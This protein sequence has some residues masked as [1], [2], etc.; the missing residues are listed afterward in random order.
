MAERPEK[1][2]FVFNADSGVINALKD[3]VHKIVSPKTYECNL[4]AVTYG[5]VS[6]KPEWKSFIRSLPVAVEFL[7]RDE[8]RQVFGTDSGDDE[9]PAV[10]GPERQL[11]ISANQLNKCSSLENLKDLVEAELQIGSGKE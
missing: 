9:F 3:A 11:L 6:M 5:S 8:F 1:L 10:F 7:H 4:C 2:I